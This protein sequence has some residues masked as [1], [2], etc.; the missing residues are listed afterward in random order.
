MMVIRPRF[1]QPTLPTS[2]FRSADASIR[3]NGTRGDQHRG[4]LGHRIV[5]GDWNQLVDD[6]KQPR[7]RL[8]GFWMSLGLDPGTIKGMDPDQFHRISK[9]LADPRRFE[10][11]EHIACARG[12]VACSKLTSDSPLSQATISHHVKELVN[13]GLIKA[14]REAKFSFYQLRRD[15]WAE[16]L[17]E[18][19]RRVPAA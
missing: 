16:Y 12:E 7:R 3:R 1:A 10:I 6:E 9:A 4:N 5:T 13:A 11:L 2:A 14:R 8:C 18:M 17:A 15:V 19:K